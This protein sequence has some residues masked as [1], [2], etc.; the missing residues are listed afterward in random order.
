MKLKV[1]F[2]D[3]FTD[4]VFS[5]NP[6]AVIILDE[7]LEK[8]TMQKIAF[9]HNLS[10][11]A[12]AVEYG[13]NSYDIRWFSPLTEIDFCGHATLAS[14]FALFSRDDSLRRLTFRAEAVGELSVL[15]KED[16]KIQMSFPERKPERIDE[17]PVDLINGLSLEPKEV[18]RSPQAYFAVYDNETDV[19]SVVQNPE[20]LKRLAP[21][22]VVVTAAS[23]KYDFISRYFWPANGGL[24]DPVTGSIHAGLAPFWSERSGKSELS[25]YQASKRGGVLSCLVDGGRV[26]VSGRAVQYLEGIADIPD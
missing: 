4:S 26:F 11:T 18:L 16:G 23:E 9:E 13:E 1:Y 21:Y 20:I 6:A 17:V 5:G 7:W 10:E 25:A 3:A 22:D 24:E 12:F 8:K 19:L 15:K 14:A 2:I